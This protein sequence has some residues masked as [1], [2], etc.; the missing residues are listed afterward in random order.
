MMAP[1]PISR[2]AEAEAMRNDCFSKPAASKRV[3]TVMAIRY[4]TSQISFN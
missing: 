3:T 4:Q 1:I 2:N